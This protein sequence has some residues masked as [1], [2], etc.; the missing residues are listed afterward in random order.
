MRKNAEVYA[1]VFSLLNVSF[2]LILL[3]QPPTWAPFLFP[4]LFQLAMSAVRMQYNYSLLTLEWA[5][6]NLS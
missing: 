3:H 5:G 1:T 6:K 2:F 4:F